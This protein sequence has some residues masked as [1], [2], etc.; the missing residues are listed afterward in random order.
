MTIAAVIE[1]DL[2]PV[3]QLGDRLK[4]ILADIRDEY[5]QPHLTPWIL[6]F[7][8]GKDS[9][10]LAQLVTEMLLSLPPRKRQRVVHIVA[11]DTLVESPV[12]ANHLNMVLERMRLAVEPLRLPIVV[13][14]T[15]PDVEQTFWV[16]L[17]GRGYPSPSRVFRWCTDRMK[18]APTTTY[19][20]S[21][22][23][24]SGQAILLL[25]VRS[26]ESTQRR[27]SVARY[28]N[29]HRLNPH[30]SLK[31]CLVYR[32]IVDLTTD[33]V[34]QT[35]LQSSPPWGGTHRE[36]VT[37]YR[38]AGGGEC[39]LVT[40]KSEAPSCG[41][42]SSRFGCWTC[43]VVEKDKSAE[44]FIEAGYGDLE[45]LLEF[46]DWLKAIREDG[47]MRMAKRRNGSLN[48]VGEGRLIPGPFTLLAR[49]EI[50]DRLVAIQSEVNMQ[51]VSPA[52]IDAIQR[53]WAEDTIA[54]AKF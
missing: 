15:V 14:K 38:N 43:T 33:E 46:R 6:G 41:T 35:L 8:G 13:A 21:Q 7:S 12:I 50:F 42:A 52:E 27:R 17:I 20:E 47:S 39:P 2:E 1:T 22:V 49:R 48:F 36:L 53:I 37:M 24:E 45:P 30:N 32:P 54:M 28:D 51:L 25:G 31:N 18:I 3:D 19:I 23:D 5:L 10:L 40:D 9:T 26:A 16:N 29:G 34:W 4:A 44:S 11:N